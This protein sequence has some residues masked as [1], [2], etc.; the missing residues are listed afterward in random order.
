MPD[1]K[2]IDGLTEI[3]KLRADRADGVKNPANGFPVLLMKAVNAQGG[4][5]EK[6]DID[7]AERALQ[8]LAQLIQNEAAEMATGQWGEVHDIEILCEAACLLKYFRCVEQ[9]GDEDD[10]EPLAKEARDSL[11]KDIE[12]F[13][14]KRKVSTAERKKLATAG[15]ALQDGSYPIDNAEDL[16]NAAVL[17][18]SGHGDV[19]AAKR[20]IAKRAKELGV[21]NPL[22]SGS[23]AKDAE[24]SEEKTSVP[25][26]G[27]TGAEN[28]APDV[29]ELVKSAVAEVS[30]AHEEAITELRD[31]LAKVRATP[32]PGGPAMSAPADM[33][34]AAQKAEKLVEAARFAK[35][36]DSVTDTDLKR[37][38]TEHAAAAKAAA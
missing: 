4:I 33:R 38:Y 24:L 19:P 16:H 12:S 7:G 36:A 32:I 5:D 35:L 28:E 10:G 30:K 18:R 15:N 34:N 21:S 11:L 29:N 23:A 9:M 6:P 26:G 20:L 31:E 17:A 14:S 8:I 22:G 2:T 37:Y 27:E 25:E 1:E 3:I 13:V